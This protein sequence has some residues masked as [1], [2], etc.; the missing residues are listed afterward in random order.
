MGHSNFNYDARST[1]ALDAAYLRACAADERASAARAGEPTLTAIHN[2]LA[3]QYEEL[4]CIM[5]NAAKLASASRQDLEYIIADR[6][7]A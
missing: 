1:S 5:D 6:G 7:R 3:L 4:A 2:E